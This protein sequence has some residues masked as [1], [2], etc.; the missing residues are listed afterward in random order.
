MIKHTLARGFT[1]LGAAAALAACTAGGRDDYVKDGDTGAAAP[2]TVQTVN[3]PTA[4]DST[5][6]VSRRTGTPGNAG[7]TNTAPTPKGTI[8]TNDNT[9]AVPGAATGA[10]AP[11]KTP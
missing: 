10:P 2:A 9:R 11:A 7:D 1:L 3:Q 5:A 4:P 8:G 6:G